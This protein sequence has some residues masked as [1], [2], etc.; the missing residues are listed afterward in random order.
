MAKIMKIKLLANTPN[1]EKIIEYA[2]RSCYMSQ[3]KITKDSKNVLLPKLLKNGHETPFEHASATFEIT[4]ISRALTHQ[5]VRHRLMSVSQ[6]SQRYVREEQFE[7]VIPPSV[8]D[9][10]DLSEY[11]SDMKSIQEM[12]NRWKTHGYKNED[13]RFVLP[14]ACATNIIITA[15]FREFRHILNLRCSKATQWEF[16]DMGF[17]LLNKLHK[18]APNCFQD[19]KEK[20]KKDFDLYFKK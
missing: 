13:A 4:G 2:A 20:Y 14:N 6:K 7:Y 15:N 10:N 9:N 16:R 3:D 19:I 17:E 5:L 1:P 8:K 18:I 12:Y 11:I